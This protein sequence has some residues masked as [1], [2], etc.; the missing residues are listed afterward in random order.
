MD[1]LKKLCESFPTHSFDIE[2]RHGSD[3]LRIDGNG[4]GISYPHELFFN[5]HG[6]EYATKE[7][8][9]DLVTSIIQ[10]L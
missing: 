9:Y 3:I 6:K 7:Y 10:F 1:L 4:G 5:S 8:V 2:L